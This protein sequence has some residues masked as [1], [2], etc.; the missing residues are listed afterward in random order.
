M[1]KLFFR[2]IFLLL[3]IVASPLLIAA[4]WQGPFTIKDVRVHYENNV[5]N[6]TFQVNED[7]MNQTC[8]YANE[9]DSFNY[10]AINDASNAM[11]SLLLSAQA[12][13]KS[14]MVFVASACRVSGQS[15]WGVNVCSD[16]QDCSIP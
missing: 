10:N 4:E 6:V 16:E 15:Y 13:A 11:L 5:Y 2:W 1:K 12:Q 9:K 8:S 14:V 7:L 3:L